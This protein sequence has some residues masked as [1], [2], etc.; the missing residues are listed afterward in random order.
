MGFSRQ[1]DGSGVPFSSPGDL[2]DPRIEPRPPALQA[3]ALPTEL[4]GSPLILSKYEN[5]KFN[6]KTVDKYRIHF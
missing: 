6:Y 2:P 4:Q 3:D 5:N 1:A